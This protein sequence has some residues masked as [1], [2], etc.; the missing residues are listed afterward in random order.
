MVAE[1]G[2]EAMRNRV[3]DRNECFTPQQ[4]APEVVKAPSDPVTC[5]LVTTNTDQGLASANERTQPRG[6]FVEAMLATSKGQ[7][8]R[9]ESA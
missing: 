5:A 4:R 9:F 7:Y 6:S 8:I 3:H 2:V 1:D